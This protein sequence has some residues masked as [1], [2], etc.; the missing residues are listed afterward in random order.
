MSS[1]QNKDTC[2][3]D[4]KGQISSMPLEH[5][6]ELG[7]KVFDEYGNIVSQKD[8]FKEPETTSTKK[9]SR[10]SKL[11]NQLKRLENKF[12]MLDDD[13]IELKWEIEDIKKILSKY[14]SSDRGKVPLQTQSVISPEISNNESESD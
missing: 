10:Y 12:N 1:D 8:A 7:L 14:N 11:K 2:L 9:K 13:L 5:A 3:V 6:L 4:Y